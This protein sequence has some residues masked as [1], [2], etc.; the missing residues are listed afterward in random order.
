M[1]WVLGFFSGGGK[2]S[3][4]TPAPVS[5][6][7]EAG[8][9]SVDNLIVKRMHLL[10]KSNDALKEAKACQKDN[11]PRAVMLMKQRQEYERQAA[12]YEGMITNLEKTSMA[13]DSAVT[14]AQ[15]AKTMQQ[16]TASMKSVMTEISVTEIEGIADDLDD[17]LQDVKYLTDALARPMGMTDE[18]DDAI[19]E[20]MAGW[21]EPQVATKPPP[22]E[23]LY[24]LPSPIKKK[25]KE[26]GVVLN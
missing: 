8:I 9:D 16:S 1:N 13:L 21:D 24:D 18:M 6:T 26:V 17:S 14:S 23:V 10:K 3:A 22:T 7:I 19:A 15:V 2:T 5:D 11:R 12:V 25:P 20:E 4:P